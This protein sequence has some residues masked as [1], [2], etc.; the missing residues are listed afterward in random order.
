[1][2]SDNKDNL[3]KGNVNKSKS[4]FFLSCIAS[5]RINPA[6]PDNNFI[7]PHKEKRGG[8]EKDADFH[9]PHKIAWWVNNHGF[10]HGRRNNI[11]LIEGIIPLS[12]FMW[13]GVSYAD[14]ALLRA[15]SAAR[16]IKDV[17]RRVGWWSSA[18]GWRKLPGRAGRHQNRSAGGSVKDW[19]WVILSWL[20]EGGR[21]LWWLFRSARFS[22]HISCVLQKSN[23]PI[24]G[25]SSST[26]SF[27][28]DNPVVTCTALFMLWI[29][30]PSFLRV[31]LSTWGG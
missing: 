2:Y 30:L 15:K 14:V 1:M 27:N 5:W 21:R 28:S 9:R 4:F 29:A 12:L 3:T 18:V 23:A 19:V 26:K 31:Q 8:E 7:T 22:T 10:R 20:K 17:C 24:N 6:P 25:R 13:Q 11:C 16:W